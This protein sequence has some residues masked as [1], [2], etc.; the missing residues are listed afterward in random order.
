[1]DKTIT[2]EGAEYPTISAPMWYHKRGLMQTATGYGARL[3]TGYK[4]HYMGRDRRIY[5][6]IYSNAGTCWIIVDK[7]QIII[8]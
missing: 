3:N 2:I 8:N 6:R 5:C 7:R 4:V 1:M